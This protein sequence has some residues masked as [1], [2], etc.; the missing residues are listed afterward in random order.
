M[1]IG[2]RNLPA[3][4]VPSFR[5]HTPPIRCFQPHACGDG[6][7]PC[8]HTLQVPEVVLPALALN[9]S[10][11]SVG[12]SSTSTIHRGTGSLSVSRAGVEWAAWSP[13][14]PW[15]VPV[16]QIYP[17]HPCFS[18]SGTYIPDTRTCSHPHTPCLTP[19]ALP[20]R[21]TFQRPQPWLVPGLC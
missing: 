12:G 8:S 21:T 3:S 4:Q 11:P 15:D 7:R 9:F 19:K 16:Q 18:Q 2:L 5:G 6:K 13:R 20:P 17:S 14:L 1:Q 10:C